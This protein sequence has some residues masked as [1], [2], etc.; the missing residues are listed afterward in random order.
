MPG[1]DRLIRLH[2]GAIMAI[3]PNFR[4]NPFNVGAASRVSPKKGRDRALST[5]RRMVC[6][7]LKTR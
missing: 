6:D 4:L 5:R 2:Y 7:T 3:V 1:T